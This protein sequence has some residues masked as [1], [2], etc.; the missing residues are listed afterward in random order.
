MGFTERALPDVFAAAAAPVQLSY[1]GYCG[2]TGSPHV[3]YT[4]CDEQTCGAAQ[5]PQFSEKMLSLPRPYLLPPDLPAAPAAVLSTPRHA[6]RAQYGL[7]RDDDDVFV[8]CSFNNANKLD[9]LMFRTWMNILRS[10]RNSVLWLTKQRDIVMKNLMAAVAAVDPALQSRVIVSPKLDRAQFVHAVPRVCD[11][12]LDTRLVCAH[13]TAAE[14]VWGGLPF[15]TMEG[16]HRCSRLAAAVV[17]S[18]GV[19]ELAVSVGFC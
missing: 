16:A 8:F 3:H 2:S 19:P 12:H 10:T 4:V 7:P 11:L 18:A 15:L 9:P 13:T 5:T 6:L 17:R 1:L 14:L